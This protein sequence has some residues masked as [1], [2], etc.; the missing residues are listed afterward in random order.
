MSKEIVGEAGDVPEAIAAIRKTN[1]D[2]VIL[3]LY[4]PGGNGF[5]VLQQEVK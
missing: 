4:M 1:P 2:M 3:D 5:D